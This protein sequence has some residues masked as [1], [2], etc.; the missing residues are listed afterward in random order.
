MRR[1][2]TRSLE[3]CIL[4]SVEYGRHNSA[5][6]LL[7]FFPHSSHQV[8]INANT[9]ALTFVQ[10][11]SFSSANLLLPSTCPTCLVWK[12]VFWA[13]PSTDAALTSSKS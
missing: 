12:R 11:T 5:H 10:P 2:G 9:K 4:G 8:T 3:T 13:Q 6:G 1:L 7:F